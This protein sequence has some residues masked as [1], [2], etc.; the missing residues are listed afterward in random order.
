MHSGRSSARLGRR[1]IAAV[2]VT[3]LAAMGL[4]ALP[5]G[6]VVN[7]DGTITVDIL[8]INDFHG[9][10]V[11]STGT[12]ASTGAPT[13]SQPGA[14]GITR[15]VQDA[16]AENADTLFVSAGDNIGASTFESMVN[17]DVPTLDFLEA[18]GLD[19]SA[20]G[21]HEFD[22]GDDKLWERIQGA[23]GEDGLGFPYLGANVTGH[24]DYAI[25]TTD[26][27]VEVG[28][29]GVVTPDT[30]NMVTP[31]G[32]ADIEFTNMADAV[33]RVTED[34]EDLADIIVVLVHDGAANAS[35]A[36]A[37]DA[38]TDFGE[39]VNVALADERI[40]A[41]FSGHTHVRYSHLLERED[42]ADLPV[43]QT[44]QYGDRIGKVSLTFDPDTG[45]VT[46][47]QPSFIELATGSNIVVEDRYLEPQL[48]PGDH[49]V[50]V[51][52][53]EAVESAEELGSVEVGEITAPFYRAQQANGSENRGGEST[54][55]NF[56]ADVQLW[57][58][59]QTVAGEGS[60]IAFMNPG[61][62]RTDLLGDG[63]DGSGA[64]TYRQVAV[65]QPFANTLVAFD[66]TGA[67]IIDVL[68]EQWQPGQSRPFLKL[69]VS[70]L[71][72][73]YD[74]LAE[75]GERITDAWVLTEAGAEPLDEAATYRVVTNS[76]LSSG[77]DSFTTLGQGANYQDT[78]LTDLD[79]MQRYFE[80]VGDGE[81]D[82]FQRAVGLTWVE[83]PIAEYNPGDTVSI[84]LSSLSFTGTTDPQP[85]ELLLELLDPITGELV[86][87]LGT[88]EVDNDVLD[89]F[90]ETGR[91]EIRIEIP[92]VEGLEEA[93]PV[94]LMASHGPLGGATP[95]D[96]GITTFVEEGDFAV[97]VEIALAATVETEPP[98]T[99]EPTTDEP[100]TAEPTTD[101]TTPPPGGSMPDTGA[102]SIGPA[103]AAVALML[104]GGLTVAAVRRQRAK[105]E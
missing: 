43:I 15:A 96:D 29:I 67:Q 91:A 30:P 71:Q 66:L 101:G 51:I 98:T 2:G 39:V 102:E 83:E 97:W 34:I 64:V 70:G 18:A 86:A 22:Q 33:E 63:D 45:E 81:P 3:T 73:L 32:V 60:L 82:Y 104:L 36:A 78:G 10:I 47:E 41:V 85:E 16:R 56:V 90:D 17:D 11:R 69:G 38:S 40:D 50:R 14:E 44:G 13:V 55:G 54:L 9:R 99:D 72:Y 75:A 12:D 6:A 105:I 95:D 76:F 37:T 42:G 61:G 49:P 46:A 31:S 21:N 23:E 20:L 74:P 19:V 58:S 68:E 93:T 5:A 79:A 8:G 52:V 77:G 28:F 92:L 27:G 48:L 57:A 88:V 62:L 26:A 1:T 103:V 100:T 4:V 53:D 24:Q 59:N 7:D 25:V 84:D 65:V 80:F 89:E 87:G 94:L 35:E